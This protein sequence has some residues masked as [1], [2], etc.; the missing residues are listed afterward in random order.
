MKQSHCGAKLSTHSV[1]R[2]GLQPSPKPQPT[3]RVA[4]QKCLCV[5]RSFVHIVKSIWP[6]SSSA[7]LLDYAISVQLPSFET[8][9]DEQVEL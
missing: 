5:Q 6:F 8:P 9:K 1:E 7:K 2:T 4:Q 3:R